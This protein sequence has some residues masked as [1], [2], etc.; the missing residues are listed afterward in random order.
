AR[1]AA[2]LARHGVVAGERR[3]QVALG[4][5]AGDW[6]GAVEAG[7]A[8]LDA[9]PG[10]ALRLEY[11][12]V[13][14]EGGPETPPAARARA[15]QA[16]AAALPDGYELAAA[17]PAPPQPVAEAAS[18][19]FRLRITRAADGATLEG[20]VPSE[21]AR[22]LIATYAEAR[23]GPTEMQLAMA[24]AGGDA[25][26]PGWEPAALVALD[27]LGRV[28]EGEAE[29]LPG[30]LRLSGRVA[31]PAEAGRIHRRMQREAPQGYA[32][33]TALTVDL[34]AAVAAVPPSPARCAALLN[35]EIAR[36]PVAFAPGEA[37]MAPGSAGMLDRLAGILERCYGARIEIGGH[38]DDRGAEEL[39]QRLSQ[40]RAE[41]VLDAL[42]TRG[43][44]LARLTARGYGEAEP[45]ATNATE[46]GRARNR[47]ID[48][49]ARACTRQA[50]C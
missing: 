26:P 34:P 15:A 43:V 21:T 25:A 13:E 14:L 39:N 27:A 40:R 6:V 38:T 46:A 5:P 3:C 28:A 17:A 12:S 33:E 42:V 16:L 4:G 49:K 18:E 2:P 11:R 10:G 19:D 32:V 8:A 22:R 45:V 9:L 1:L 30:R 37:V 50:P 23:L 7:L 48:F 24:P 47:R 35:A 44:P 41:A 29:L 20:L 31:G 36:R